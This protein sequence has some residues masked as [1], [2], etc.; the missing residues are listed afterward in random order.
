M[1]KLQIWGF[2]LGRIYKHRNHFLRKL[3]EEYYVAGFILT[4]LQEFHRIFN[5]A[6]ID[7]TKAVPL[8]DFGRQ[9]SP[10]RSYHTIRGW[11]L[12][13]KLNRRTG[14]RVKLESVYLP[15]GLC[16]DVDAFLRFV[17]RLNGADG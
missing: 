7:P 15:A 1:N 5:M 8:K 12:D 13:G 16:T 4:Y 3:Q 10:R 14:E 11:C 9:L 2:D 6:N 17:E